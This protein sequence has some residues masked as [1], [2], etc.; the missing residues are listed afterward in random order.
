MRRAR[1]TILL[2]VGVF[3]F[4]AT[5]A[6]TAEAMHAPR[7]A[8]VTTVPGETTT[9]APTTVA[10]TTP[11]PSTTESPTTATEPATSTTSPTTTTVAPAATSSSSTSPWGWVI[12]ILA[13]LAVALIVVLVLLR[14]SANREKSEWRNAAASALRDAD[15]TRDMLADEAR[16]GEAE[17]AARVAAVRGTVERV[18]GQF[19]QLATSA[20]NDAMRSSS[21]GVATS[22]RGYF[23]ALEAEQMLHNAPTSPTADQLAAADAAKRARAAELEAAMSAIRADIAPGQSR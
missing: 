6:A 15:L 9:L 11:A 16:P 17:D 10:T 12:A 3:A 22:L 5:G 21:I 1:M 14:R 23:F 19:D 18:A 7:P 20:P 8:Q 13:V 4:V 2:L